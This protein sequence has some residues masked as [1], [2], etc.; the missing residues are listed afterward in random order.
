[1]TL[2]STTT[3][4]SYT[5][6]GGT[7]AFPVTFAFFGTTTTAQLEVIERTIATGA[8]ATL[9]NG[10]DYTVSGG[11][12]ATGTVTATSAPANTVE[13]HIR[14]NTTQTQGTD[15]VENDPFPAATHENALDRLT[16]I[17]QEQEADHAL[18]FSFPVTYTGGASTA[19]PE[20]SASKVL[21]W[22]SA[23]DA[24]ENGPTSTE[25]SN[26]QTYATA[27]A[28][29]ASAASASATLASEWATKT[30]GQVAST[31]YSSKAWAI[32]GTGVTD[33]ASAGAAKEWATA[34][35]DDLVD[36]TEYSAKHYSAKASASASAASTS[37]TNAANSAAAAAASAAGIF[38]KEPVV[39]ATTANITLSG[40]Q[41]IDGVLTSTSRI[42]V[43][44]Q[45]NAAEN[46]V[47]VTASGAWARATPLDTW[48]E[49]VGAAVIV[50]DGTTNADTA[51]ICTVDAGG[52]LETTDITWGQ[53]SQVYSTA[54]T[55]S[56]GIT[57][58][59]TAAEVTTGTDAT[60]SI[61]PDALA[62]SNYGTAVVQIFVFDD[63]TDCA[64]GDG[65]GDVFFRV[66][67]TINGFDLVGV[68]AQC[69]TAGTTGTMDVQIHNVTQ[70]A[71]MLTTKITIDSAETDSSTAATAAVIDT[72]NDDVATGDQIRI[73]VD[74][75]H[76]TA[77]KGLLVELQFRLP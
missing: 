77:A 57:E 46:G 4:V 32:G 71:D 73:D 25:I 19:V 72:A 37:E 50:S 53:L 34:A 11:N 40:E 39:N 70:A 67:S 31:D 13:W 61:T 10:T 64:T 35:E 38:W 66:P 42:L 44:N 55:S 16:M 33:T 18:T 76:T 7:T 2:S 74:A 6:D 27:A 45:T 21:Q 12:N 48:D 28:A 29:S 62:G 17:A 52:T 1:M 43:K 5:G 54:T 68:A 58:Y 36:G 3:E 41:T 60:R 49:H 8:E 63:A 26:A 22:N 9:V 56:E 51:W 30:D 75:V 69:Q 20:P 15:Y 47:Y 59:A 24:L 14:R 65:A 23:A